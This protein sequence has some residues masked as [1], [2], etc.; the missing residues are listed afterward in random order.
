MSTHAFTHRTSLVL[1]LACWRVSA[2]VR[3]CSRLALRPEL[4]HT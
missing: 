4:G 2:R 1:H 3:L